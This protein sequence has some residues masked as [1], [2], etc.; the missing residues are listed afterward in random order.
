[1][2]VHIRHILMRRVDRARI[3]SRLEVGQ[4]VHGAVTHSADDNGSF[5]IDLADG[6]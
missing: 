2:R 6:C 1:M 3:A 5:G 4:P